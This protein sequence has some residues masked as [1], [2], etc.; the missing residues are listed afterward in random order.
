MLWLQQS[1]D[2]D[3]IGLQQL[4]PDNSAAIECLG[5]CAYVSNLY[6]QFG[7]LWYHLLLSSCLQQGCWQHWSQITHRLLVAYPCLADLSQLQLQREIAHLKQD[8]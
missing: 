6:F 8:S 4:G 2:S 7:T 3:G 5:N 1:T